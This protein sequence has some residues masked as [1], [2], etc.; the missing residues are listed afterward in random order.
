MS[1]ELK[2][3]LLAARN[4]IALV[5]LVTSYNV[6]L[7]QTKSTSSMVEVVKVYAENERYF[8]VSTPF[9]NE[10][11]T[12]RGV[13]SVFETGNTTPL[14]TFERGFDSVSSDSN[15]L[16]LSNDGQTIFYLLDFDAD[17]QTEGLKSVTIYR[18]GQI[19]RSYT[20]P[21]VTGCNEQLDEECNLVYRNDDEVV[22]K[23]K[24]NWGTV[25][26]KKVFKENVSE[27]EKFL[28]D[29]AVFRADDVVFVTDSKKN[30]H[31]FDLKTGEMNKPQPFEEMFERLK[32]I[33]RQVRT[34]LTRYQ[35]PTLLE[36]PKL[37]DGRKTEIAFAKA[38]GLKPASIFTNSDD[39][40]KV[41]TLVVTYY[42]QRD[43]SLEIEKLDVGEGLPAAKI[44][45]FLRTQRFDV[46]F[47]PKAFDKW[48]A[49]DYLYFRKANDQVARLEKKKELKGQQVEYEYRLTQEYLN[50]I[51][52]PANLGDCFSELD[53]LLP[54]SDKNKIRSL[55]NR[56]DTV[57]YH[58][59]LGMWMRNNWGL[60]AGSRLQKYMMD[61]G[62]G[63]PDDMSGVI[64]D[65]YYDW[66]NG[67]LDTWKEWEKKASKKP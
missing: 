28:N 24:S 43:G 44:E 19:Y 56:D 22:D 64:L 61:H 39:Q 2:S 27:Q 40:F 3:S 46:S 1:L 31:A 20:A 58:M 29:Y 34:E 57:A 14:Y 42:L 12:M 18:N 6:A 54:E 45:E 35:A 9:D 52:I 49:E 50:K 13:T 51:Y 8:L 10:F 65:Y 32:N 55:P 59:G 67:K 62:V 23:E 4:A 63:H 16:V 17:E 5:V 37:V 15:N 66:L 26:Y 53:K 25:Q 7:S 36:F 60:W 41:Y 33:R 11:P 48:Y 30:L 21:E 47:I 38:L